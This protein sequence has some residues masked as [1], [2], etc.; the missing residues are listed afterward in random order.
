MGIETITSW[1]TS[2]QSEVRSEAVRKCCIVVQ[3]IQK[4][5]RVVQSHCPQW[6]GD[7]E[8]REVETWRKSG[9]KN[10]VKRFNKYLYWHNFH[11]SV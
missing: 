10:N 5:W 11:I 2:V 8:Y 9:G 7:M 1:S 3:T 4:G 6:A